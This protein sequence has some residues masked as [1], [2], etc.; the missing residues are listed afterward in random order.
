MD[1]TRLYTL[2]FVT[3]AA[4]LVFE[5]TGGRLLAP[6]LGT[7]V[8]VWAGLIT[9]VLGGMAIGYHFGGKYADTGASQKRIGTA[10]FLAGVA[11]LIAWGVRDLIPGSIVYL[12]IETTLGALIAG[13]IIFMPTVILL[14]AVSPMIA[15]NLIQKL[16][17]SG[18]TVGELNAVGTAGSIA[19]AIGTGMILIPLFGVSAILLGVSVSVLAA[20]FFLL[21]KDTAKFAALGAL[22]FALA[23]GA[24]SIPT[25]TGRLVADISTA[26]NRIFITKEHSGKQLALWT[27]PFGIQCEMFVDEKGAVDETRLAADYQRAHDIVIAT[28]F[29]DGPSRML[30]LGGC[31]ESF[32]RYL[33]KKYPNASADVVEIDPGMIQ[34]AEKYFGLDKSSF[35]ALH[36]VYEDA[37]TFINGTHAPYNVVYMDVFTS[38]SLPFQLYTKEMFEGLS[39]HTAEGG[40]VLINTI[41]TFEGKDL[42]FPSVV[43]KTAREVFPH[44]DLYQF[45]GKPDV[46]QN[47]VILASKTRELPD[48][49]TSPE[50][51]GFTLRKTQIDENVIALTDD[52]A[53]VE[54]VFPGVLKT[55]K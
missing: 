15:K 46:K 54:G 49:F 44:A 29:P 4:I 45:T 14:A 41:G 36:T 34:V 27:S 17:T 20:G 23:L 16:D 11:A 55:Q 33:L 40:I 25:I 28:E 39:S 35:P 2:S 31:V 47:L 37:R 51:P 6:Y 3:N 53:P 52:Y 1:R 22:S 38:G 24:N 9:V 26:Y 13:T 21:K 48:T 10:L 18:K 32:P 7:G 8:G 50:Y 12:Q 30:F 43:I 42:L 19:G 5:I